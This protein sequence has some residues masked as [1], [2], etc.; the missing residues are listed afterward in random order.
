[1][2][3]SSLFSI[4]ADFDLLEL[5]HIRCLR[6]PRA[7]SL[8]DEAFLFMKCG[9]WL[10]S[11]QISET[12]SSK[13]KHFRVCYVYD[14]NR[15]F[16]FVVQSDYPDQESKPERERNVALLSSLSGCDWL[17]GEFALSLVCVGLFA[18]TLLV[19]ILGISAK[20]SIISPLVSGSLV[21]DPLKL[22]LSSLDRLRLSLSRV[23]RSQAPSSQTILR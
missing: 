22:T 16:S 10:N 19:A 9:F 15:W 5:S 18:L 11:L 13:D 23:L 17:I 6:P 4:D 2:S 1:M 3:S 7:L 21:S 8:S 12:F 14:V 20:L